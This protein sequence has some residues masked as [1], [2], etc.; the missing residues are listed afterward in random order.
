MP[1]R[2]SWARPRSGSEASSPGAAAV[3]GL[4]TAINRA[5]GSTNGAALAAQMVKF[6]KVPTLSGLVS[7]SPTL[8]SVSGRQYRVIK[9]QDN[10]P[11]VVGHRGGQ[12]RPEDLGTWPPP[13]R[14]WTTRRPGGTLRAVDVSRS[15]EGVHAVQGISLSL[16]RHEVL[17]LIGPNGAG[18]STL[19]NLLTGF[20]FPTAGAVELDGTRRL[21]HGAPTVAA[22][23]ASRAPSSIRTHS[24]G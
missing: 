6:N 11:K 12:G 22:A 19:V 13:K 5:G 2:K 24:G 14:S 1:S 16:H 10:K 9:I 20:D 23:T 3:D 21:R 4:V 8:H 17:G 18:K 7:F 15:F